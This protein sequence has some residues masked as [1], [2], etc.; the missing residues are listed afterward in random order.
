MFLGLYNN[1]VVLVWINVG[2]D[3]LDE[4][5]VLIGWKKVK[6]FFI[7]LGEG[8]ILVCFLELWIYLVYLWKL[9]ISIRF[10]IGNVR[11]RRGCCY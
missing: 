6:F 5:V 8:S 3:L 1:N 7:R 10:N 9:K 11:R 2:R 4:I